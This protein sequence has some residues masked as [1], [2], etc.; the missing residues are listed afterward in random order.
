M[1]GLDMIE[2]LHAALGQVLAARESGL[3]GRAWER[4]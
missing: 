2:A 3:T 4:K 1:P